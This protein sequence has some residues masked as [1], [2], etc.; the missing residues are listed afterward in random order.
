METKRLTTPAAEEIL[1][2]Y[3]PVL[4]HGFVSLVDY[5]GGDLAIEQAAR[6]SYGGTGRAL[7]E[8]RD[9]RNLLRYMQ[10]HRHTS[11]NEMV[12]LKF[13]CSMPIFVARQWI[14]HRT[15]NVNEQSGRYSIL[16]MLFYMPPEEQLR[17]Q[18]QVNK[19]G[20]G[21]TLSTNAQVLACEKWAD[22]REQ[23]VENYNWL[24]ENDF[25]RELAR[26]DLPLST[27][28]Q[29]Y[30]KIDLHNL[31]HFLTLRVDGHA[32]W[33]IQQYGK[34]MAGMFK[35]VAPIAYEA[36]IDY[37]VCGARLSRMELETLRRLVVAF[38]G[39][40]RG[41]QVWTDKEQ[42]IS[43]MKASGMSDRETGALCDLFEDKARPIPDFEL[44]LSQV[45]PVAYFEEQA[46]A[47][48]TK[49]K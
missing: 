2:L 21:E 6:V 5:M 11:V 15:A 29:W 37:E 17:A 41:V 3:F 24:C 13:H 25:A 36:W 35:R 46:A 23:A 34:I 14:R 38:E 48:T 4:D 20:R 28:T 1:G 22:Q 7:R 42:T 26:I 45:K 16:P 49:G 40:V 43:H 18:S 30:W 19:Q 27:Y 8:G 10:R 12:E 32:Q 9:T 47:A 31:M 33:E 39:S 44:D